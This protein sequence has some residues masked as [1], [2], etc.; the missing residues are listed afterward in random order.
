MPCNI[1]SAAARIRFML[2]C[3]WG[4]VLSGSPLGRDGYK[5]SWLFSFFCNGK[6]DLIRN[7]I[8]NFFQVIR[9]LINFTSNHLLTASSDKSIR[10]FVIFVFPPFWFFNDIFH[11]IL[12]SLHA[13]APSGNWMSNLRNE[14]KILHLPKAQ[15]NQALNHLNKNHF[16]SGVTWVPNLNPSFSPKISTNLQPPKGSRWA[17]NGSQMVKNT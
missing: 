2:W 16:F 3:Y 12:C 17:Q 14:T 1:A 13:S 9:L 10:F 6:L 5:S 8:C 11:Q 7:P 4:Q 15:R